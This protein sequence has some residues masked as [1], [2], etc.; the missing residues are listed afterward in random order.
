M[1]A[2]LTKVAGLSVGHAQND[3]KTTGV[4][5]VRFR[6]AAPTVVHVLGGASATYDTGSLSLD[7]T[8][9]RRWAIFLAGGSLFGL[10]AARGV[11][12]ALLAS[13]AG[14]RVFGH[15]QRLAPITGAALFDLPRLGKEIPD[16]VELGRKAVSTASR[17]PVEM[18]PVGAGT[19]ATVAKYLGRRFARRG[20]LGSAAARAPKL[21]WVGV[22]AAVNS[23]GAVWDPE[24]G[25][26]AAV[27]RE[28]GG[29]PLAPG[30][31][32]DVSG[33]QVDSRGTTLVVV[34]CEL[35]LE[36]SALQRIG[37]IAA[38]GLARCIMPVFTATDG[39]VLFT[40]STERR[41]L[42]GGRS[43]PMAEADELG[44]IAAGL[45]PRAV[46]RAVTSAGVEAASSTDRAA[47]S[48][49]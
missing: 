27:A 45:I 40:A 24:I 31:F 37:S 18:G 30:G 5:V 11:R 21:G 39:D 22:I 1:P 13:G 49:T 25:H 44:A 9:G 6:R 34:V 16:Y 10:D 8:F 4:T 12:N 23:V 46:V 26:W 43:Y 32:R 48:Q 7:A 2:T 33:R 15:T 29:P 38:A 3:G 42:R 36:R 35:T 41:S 47:S 19:G 28:P 14:G 20:G 17:K